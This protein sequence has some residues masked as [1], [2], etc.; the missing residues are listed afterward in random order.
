MSAPPADPVRSSLLRGIQIEARNAE[1]YMTFSR[2]FAGYEDGVA[3]IFREMAAEE[4]QHGVDLE[5]RY[6]ERYG[7][8]PTDAEETRDV[9]EA[10]DLEDAEA[11]IFDSMTVEQALVAGLKAERMAREFYLREQDRVDDSALQALYRE[12]AEFEE[13]HVRRL[14]ERLAALR[15]AHSSREG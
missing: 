7:P 2:L 11:L 6:Q 13:D 4:R 3:A 15:Q 8:V 10:P 12:L 9:I 1:I 5:Q 14:E